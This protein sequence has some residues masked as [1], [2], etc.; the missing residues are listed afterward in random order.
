MTSRRSLH[1]SDFYA[2]SL[3]Q[4]RLLRAGRI[5]E[6]DL[7]TIAE[8]IEG[9][10]RT[11]KR[12]LVSRFTVLLLHLLKW[13]ISRLIAA[14]RGALSMANARNEITDHLEDNPQSEGRAR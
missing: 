4:A 7:E 13:A 9:M 12:E 3:E 8:E 11:E 6:A 5:G 14:S 2:W 1:D 10:G